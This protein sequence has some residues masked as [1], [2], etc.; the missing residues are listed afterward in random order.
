MSKA[1]DPPPAKAPP[2]ATV[3]PDEARPAA[4]ADL[5]DE[6]PLEEIKLLFAWAEGDARLG[7][8]AA[9]GACL[10]VLYYTSGL[11]LGPVR[12]WPGNDLG[13]ELRA[14]LGPVVRGGA[15]RAAMVDW[16]RLQAVVLGMA[17]VLLGV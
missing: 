4:P 5:S 14:L 13:V 9:L 6:L 12:S 3:V 7:R 1:K 11:T 2:A 10:A 17:G 8:R 16:R 15:E